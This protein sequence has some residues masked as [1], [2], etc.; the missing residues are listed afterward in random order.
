[1]GD[2]GKKKREKL[3]H[4]KELTSLNLDVAQ[5][6]EFGHSIVSNLGRDEEAGRGSWAPQNLGRSQL[7]PA[8]EIKQEKNHEIGLDIRRP[9]L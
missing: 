3:E 6:T 7:R 5:F 8:K 1:M 2:M 4:R 9:S